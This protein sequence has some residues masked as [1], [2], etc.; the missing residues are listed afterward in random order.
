MDTHQLAPPNNPEIFE[1]MICDLFNKIESTNTYKKFGGHGNLQKGIDVFSVEKDTAIQCK[2]KDLSRRESTLKN[3]LLNDIK[4]DVSSVISKNLAIR[5]TKLYIMSTY[6][7][8]PDVDEFCEDLKEQLN[9]GFEIIYW[10]WNTVQSKI[11]NHKSLL[12]KYYPNFIINVKSDEEILI[13]DLDLKKQI[14]KNFSSWLDYA[15]ENRKLSSKMLLR[16]FQG[17]QYPDSNEPDQFNEYS[18]FAA[19]IHQLY[20]RGM[21]FVIGIYGICPLPDGK[22]RLEKHSDPDKDSVKVRKIGQINFSDIISY[23]IDGDEY[24]NYPHIFCR[25]SYR[26]IPFEN[27][28][29]VNYEKVYEQYE[30]KDQII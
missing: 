1:N 6:K 27:C 26:G 12:E 11:L 13:R 15:P 8:H 2:K 19:E 24:Y 28:Y 23:D 25:F 14:K 17:T 30:L 18:W 22:W 4:K 29:Y 20:H 9:T 7:D 3:E 16:D 5:I 21:E 10:G